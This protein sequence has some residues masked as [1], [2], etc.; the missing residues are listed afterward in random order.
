[1][2]ARMPEPTPL[3]FERVPRGIFGPL[4]DPYAELY[5]EI[6]AE[7]YRREFEREPF[8]VTRLTAG[9]DRAPIPPAQRRHCRQALHA[10]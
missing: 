8:V 9:Q 2:V 1:M 3:L 10:P 4:G 6:L 7:L 5:W